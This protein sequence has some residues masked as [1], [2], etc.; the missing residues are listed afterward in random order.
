MKQVLI[1]ASF[2]R[3]KIIWWHDRQSSLQTWLLKQDQ[4]FLILKSFFFEKHNLPTVCWFS[5]S[6]VSYSKFCQVLICSCLWFEQCSNIFFLINFTKSA[7]FPKST[8]MICCWFSLC[9]LMFDSINKKLRDKNL[10]L[11]LGFWH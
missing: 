5:F 1:L 11:V 4:D 9:F 6:V 8:I 7:S 2:W 3:G 10:A